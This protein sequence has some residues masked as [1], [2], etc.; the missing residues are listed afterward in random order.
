[1]VL[2]LLF[3]SKSHLSTAAEILFLGQVLSG[4][5]TISSKGGIFELGFFTPGSQTDW[6]SSIW[7]GGCKRRTPLQCGGNT[8]V[9]AEKDGFFVMR[10]VQLPGNQRSLTTVR[11][12]KECELYCLNNCSCT[13]Y[14][15]DSSF[16]VWNGDLINLKQMLDGNV[17]GG[18][19]YLRLAAIDLQG[20]DKHERYLAPKWISGVAITSKADVYSYGM[21]LFEIIS[22]KRNAELFGDGE[23]SFFP[24]WAAEKIVKDEV[25]SLLD[26]RLDGITNIEELRRASRVAC[27][28][29]QD[30]ENDRPSME[31][32][33][34]ILEGERD[35]GMPPIPWSIK[36]L[37]DNSSWIS[38]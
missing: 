8:F 37:T 16:S 6:N 25:L 10:N 20:F 22:G 31:L 32:V 13:A 5:Q 9:D 23:S 38:S 24:C 30:N 2:P 26:Y 34:Q 36:I 19:L 18:D 7:S 35:V 4:V 27:W 12:A 1:M 28:C 29:I 14:A 3:F 33:V 17:G 15:Y 11:S 21:M